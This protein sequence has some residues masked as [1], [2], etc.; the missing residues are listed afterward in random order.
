MN[1]GTK[2]GSHS[3]NGRNTSMNQSTSHIKLQPL[4]EVA[5]EVVV[6]PPT[7]S[8]ARRA[9]AP[10]SSHVYQNKVVL[11]MKDINSRKSS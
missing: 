2:N 3:S 11:G 1:I 5:T 6:N 7:I 4:K 9:P 10:Q 8:N